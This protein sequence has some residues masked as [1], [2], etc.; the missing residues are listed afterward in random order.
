MV[1]NESLNITA[2]Q[3]KIQQF[4]TDRDWQQFHTPKNIAMALT[5]EAA[6]LL[7][8]FQWLTPEESLSMQND[9]KW[10]ERVGEE[11]SDVL[12]YLFRM[13]DHLNINLPEA[14]ESK[15]EKN[16]KKYPAELVRGKSKK[17]SE[18]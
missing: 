1:K 18:Y 9:A 13:A 3:K 7:E 4:A 17:Y 15:M 12:L 6:E 5:V 10:K 11:M 14:I 8:L 16:A 2:L